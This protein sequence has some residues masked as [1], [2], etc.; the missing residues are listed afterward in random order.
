MTNRASVRRDVR[1]NAA[2][3]DVWAVVG[4]PTRLGEWFPGVASCAV[5]GTSRVVT[6]GAGLPMP[7]ELLTVDRLQRRFQYRITAPPFREHLATVDVHDLGDGT[8]LVVYGTD[9][10]PATMALVL[11][12]AA[13][14]ALQHLRHMMEGAS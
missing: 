6:T 14:N 4:D 10:D 8:S 1:I 5:E 3:D 9:A 2:P 13:G 11:G 12:G 7:E